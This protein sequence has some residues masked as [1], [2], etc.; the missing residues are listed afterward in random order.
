M[1]GFPVTLPEPFMDVVL[2]LPDRRDGKVRVRHERQHG[3]LLRFQP[4]R[5]AP[6]GVA[7]GIEPMHAVRQRGQRRGAQL[8]QIG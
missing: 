6:R 8:H 2:P 7:V 4:G 1:G 3:A 5:V